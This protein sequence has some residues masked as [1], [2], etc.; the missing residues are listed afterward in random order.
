MYSTTIS[1]E[2]YDAMA[3]LQ[4]RSMIAPARD[5][6]D[7]PDRPYFVNQ[8]L[9]DED[10][11]G[12][13]EEENPFIFTADRKAE[14]A[15]K[16]AERPIVPRKP[17]TP[18]YRPSFVPPKPATPAVQPVSTPKMDLSGVGAGTIVIHKAFGEGI[19][20]KIEKGQTGQVYVYVKFGKNEKSF[21][22][23]GAFYDGYLKVK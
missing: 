9:V 16:A 2:E 15:T 11:E 23:P 13:E 20:R 3:G 21:G 14:P 4:Q 10:E 7:I 8:P 18:T 17:I 5:E 12:E 19:V 1:K 6:S 22:F